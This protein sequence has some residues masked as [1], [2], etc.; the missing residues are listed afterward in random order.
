M[1]SIAN[2]NY[3][4]KNYLNK[5]FPV[6]L[7]ATGFT[8]VAFASRVDGSST[9]IMEGEYPPLLLSGQENKEFSI[10]NDIIGWV[11]RNE[12]AVYSDGFS[13]STPVFGKREGV[14]AFGCTV[15]IPVTVSKSTCGVLCLAME[16]ARSISEELKIFLRLAADD[17]ARLLEVLSLRYRLR[18]AEKNASSSK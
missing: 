11:F 3:C 12:E 16:E 14:P 7:D 15:C 2:S 9:Y 8:Y 13:G 4:W 10:H 17:L 1:K 18:M 6:L 5:I